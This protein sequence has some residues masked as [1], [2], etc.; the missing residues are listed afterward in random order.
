MLGLAVAHEHGGGLTAAMWGAG[1][2]LLGV[3]EQWGTSPTL[4]PSGH[5]LATRASQQGSV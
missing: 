5:R 4:Q 1:V 3:N 2:C